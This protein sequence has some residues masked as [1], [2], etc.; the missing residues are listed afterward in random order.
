MKLQE[1]FIELRNKKQGLLATNFY[2][3]ET[4]EGV[5]QAAK[6]TESTADFTTYQKLNKLSRFTCCI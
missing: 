5:L 4:L 3:F 2:N 1:K 6:S